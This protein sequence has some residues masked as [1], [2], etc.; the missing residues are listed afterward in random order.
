MADTVSAT[1]NLHYALNEIHAGKAAA[2]VPYI[3]KAIAALAATASPSAPATAPSGSALAPLVPVDLASP[4][5]DTYKYIQQLFAIESGQSP[6]GEWPSEATDPVQRP[7]AIA[8]TVA[9]FLGSGPAYTTDTLLTCAQVE[10]AAVWDATPG[11][12]ANPVYFAALQRAAQFVAGKS[13][14]IPWAGMDAT[15]HEIPTGSYGLSVVSGWYGTGE[16]PQPS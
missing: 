3:N 6:I 10:A 15:V 7:K 2:A 9:S 14:A 8:Q 5:P 16:G 1:K 11:L 13:G 12:N 4:S